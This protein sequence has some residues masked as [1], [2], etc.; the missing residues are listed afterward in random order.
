[1]VSI[2][3]S[4]WLNCLHEYAAVPSCPLSVLRRHCNE[5]NPR[6]D[7]PSL[8]AS[9]SLTLIYSH[10]RWNWISLTNF[11]FFVFLEVHHSLR[12]CLSFHIRFHSRT[13][14]RS[15]ST[16]NVYVI[17]GLSR[18]ET[19][20]LA[21]SFVSPSSVVLSNFIHSTFHTKFLLLFLSTFPSSSPTLPWHDSEVVV[22]MSFSTNYVLDECSMLIKAERQRLIEDWRETEEFEAVGGRAEKRKCCVV[23]KLAVE[24]EKMVVLL[25][26]RSIF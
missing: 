21:R 3:Y 7:V 10:I 20:S 23:L 17:G 1:M 8:S 2:F 16:S 15:T 14:T 26:I 4:V 24:R 25:I 19:F 12:L 13:R 22:K 6:L 9:A 5:E 18:V 11:L